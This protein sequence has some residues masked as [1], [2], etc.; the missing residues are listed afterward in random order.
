MRKPASWA[1]RSTRRTSNGKGRRGGLH[2]KVACFLLSSLEATRIEHL[3]AGDSAT[4]AAA[5][6]C[7]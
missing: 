2:E 4:H 6:R 7:H 3:C 1:R 5:D